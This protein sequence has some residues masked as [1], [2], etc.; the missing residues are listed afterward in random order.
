LPGEE[1]QEFSF[2]SPVDSPWAEN[3]TV[4]GLA[5]GPRDAERADAER[6]IV[7]LHGAYEDRYLHPV[8]MARSFTQHG[9][10]VLIPAGPCHLQ[11]TPPGVFSGSPMFWSS[12]LFVAGMH[13]WLAEVRGLIGW[14]R[15]E[16]TQQVGLFGNSLGSL[17]AGMAATLWSDIDLVALLSPVGSHLDSIER[18]KVAARIWPWMSN[19]KPADKDLLTRWAA[20]PRWAKVSRLGFFITQHDQLQ[21]TALQEA[22]WR[23]WGCPPRW[24]Y[25]HAHL[26][27]HYCKDFYRDLAAFANPTA[28]PS[29]SALPEPQPSDVAQPLVATSRIA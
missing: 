24:D 15:R 10:R 12:E 7:L 3:Q 1:L 14:L 22:W 19:L 2:A 23:D 26:S 6:A 4:R 16:G 5:L 27:V 29:A 20:A 9:Y 17:A 8:W 13:Q 25:R 11:R 21:P 28:T 18:S